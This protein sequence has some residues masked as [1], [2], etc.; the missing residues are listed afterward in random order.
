VN[1]SQVIQPNIQAS[2]GVIHAI[3]QVLIPP[4][5][6]QEQQPQA[7]TDGITPGRATRGGRSYIG[8]AGNIGF[9]GDTALGEGSFSVISKLGLTR[10]LSVRP[11]AVIGDDT[12]VLVPLTLDFSPRSTEAVGET[13]SISP[14]IGAGIAIETSGDADVGLLLTGGLDVPLGNRFTLNGAVNAAFL[15]DTDVGLLFGIGYNF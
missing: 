2:N 8:V 11:T 1:N 7:Q 4:N 14:Y 15:N 9:G 6:S 5:I 3:N 13:F 10:N 12:V